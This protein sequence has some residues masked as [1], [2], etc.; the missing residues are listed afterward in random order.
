KVPV[1]ATVNVT[2]SAEVSSRYPLVEAL[3]P[4]PQVFPGSTA[5]SLMFT[6]RGS[7][8]VM[9]FAGLA[10]RSGPTS[11]LLLQPW[12]GDRSIAAFGPQPKSLKSVPLKAATLPPPASAAQS[13]RS[14]Q[15]LTVDREAMLSGVICSANA[16]ARANTAGYV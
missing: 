2:P 6:A 3:P 13:R 8:T 16:S 10:M 5:T 12:K 1:D 9:N 11:E 14:A 4:S 7:F 15:S